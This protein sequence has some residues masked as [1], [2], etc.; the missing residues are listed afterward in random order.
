MR[1]LLDQND[2]HHIESEWPHFIFTTDD[3]TIS[4]SRNIGLFTETGDLMLFPSIID[5]L[6]LL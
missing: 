3:H 4:L 6:S 1:Q 5:D 2:L